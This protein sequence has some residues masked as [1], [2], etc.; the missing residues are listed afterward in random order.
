MALK[1]AA[2]VYVTSNSLLYFKASVMNFQM[3]PP[4]NPIFALKKQHATVYYLNILNI[5]F[6]IAN[7]E[8][9]SFISFCCVP[10]FEPLSYNLVA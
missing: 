9:Y 4:R 1:G 7:T 8:H 10:C 2:I 5:E 3:L 6:L